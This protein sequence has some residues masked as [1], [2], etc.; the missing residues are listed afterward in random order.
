MAVVKLI[1]E[2]TLRSIVEQGHG[3]SFECDNCWR[4]VA[5][6]ALDLIARFGA[7]ATVGSGISRYV[8]VE[9]FALSE[10]SGLAGLLGRLPHG[11]SGSFDG[12]RSH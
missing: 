5:V 1:D 10:G 12:V 9:Q 7:V 11:E 6:D 4:L 3:L 8:T 2:M